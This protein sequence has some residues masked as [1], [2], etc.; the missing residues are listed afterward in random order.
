[1]LIDRLKA[2]SQTINVEASGQIADLPGRRDLALEGQLDY[3]P[4]QLL[5]LLKPYL[6]ERIE[7]TAAREAHPF[8]L[9]GPL[10]ALAAG[11]TGDAQQPAELVDALYRQFNAEGTAG[12]IGAN[13]YGFRVGSGEIRGHLEDGLLNIEPLNLAVSEGRLTAE[14]RVRLWPEPA[15]LEV[16]SGQLLS[17]VRIS[18]EMCDAGLQYIAPVL[19]G[20]T[21]AQGT[22]SIALDGCRIPLDHPDRGELAGKFSVHTVDIG[23]GPLVRELA[24]LLERPGVARLSRES[25]VPFKMVDGRVY[26]RDLELVFPELTIRTHGSVGLDRSLAIMAEMPVPPK[27]IGANPLGTALKN[28]TIRLPIGGTLNEPKIDPKALAQ[29]SA[30]FVK[31]GARNLLLDGLNRGLDRLLKPPD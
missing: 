20:V 8:S 27:W 30:E 17:K 3:E 6:G 26:H 29:V 23:P 18:P 2:T 28:Q 15:Q 25:V 1:L 22:F 10:A 14:P 31:A 13:V 9:E 7:I 19:A 24:T 16:D 21:Q 5:D 12:W 11:R 4:Q